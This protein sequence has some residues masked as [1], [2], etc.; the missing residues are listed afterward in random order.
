[1]RV[2]IIGEC[3][4]SNHWSQYNEVYTAA[5]GHLVCIG[6]PADCSR[7]KWHNIFIFNVFWECDSYIILFIDRSQ[8]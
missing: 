2:L 5:N 1:L 6:N 8:L 7:K 3:A 4:L